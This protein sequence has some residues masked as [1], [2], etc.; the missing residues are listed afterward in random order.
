MLTAGTA[1]CQV[2][3]PVEAVLVEP[4]EVA[5]AQ[6]AGGGNKKFYPNTTTTTR[7]LGACEELKGEVFDCSG[8]RL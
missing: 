2:V 3:V 5:L 6:L 7:F 4:V 8:Y 1:K